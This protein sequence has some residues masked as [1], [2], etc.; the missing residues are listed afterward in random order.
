MICPKC[1]SVA[2]YSTSENKGRHIRDC[3]IC[4]QCL[5]NFFKRGKLIPYKIKK[6]ITNKGCSVPWGKSKRLKI[7]PK[8][9]KKR[10]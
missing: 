5:H 3:Y 7:N 6:G 8:K 9:K 1:G 4:P 10:K 2:I